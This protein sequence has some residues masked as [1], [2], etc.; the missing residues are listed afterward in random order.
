MNSFTF[1]QGAT[2]LFQ[3][4]AT[5]TG[6]LVINAKNV[7]SSS[8][9]NPFILTSYNGIATISS[10]CT[11]TSG[12]AITGDSVNGFTVDNLKIVNGSSTIYG[13]LLENQSTTWATQFMSVKNS[14]ITGFAPVSGSPNGGEIW[15]IGY[16]MNGNKGPLNNIQILN[17]SLHGA[18]ITSP[19]GVGVGGYGYGQ[20]ITNVLVQG[21]TVYNLGM[22]AAE[23]GAGILANGWKTGTIQRNQVHDIGANVTSCGGTSG[24]ETYNSNAVTVAYNEVF[25]VQPSPAYTAGCDWN[26]IDLDGGTTNSTVEYNYTHNNAGAGYLGY[27][28]N[29]SG[30]TWGP[31]TYRYNISENDDWEAAEGGAFAIVPNAPQNTVSIYSNTLFNNLAERGNATPACFYFG[32]A[33]GTWA[34][35]SLIEDNICDINNPS[36][37]ANLYNNPYGQTGMTLSNNLYFSSSNPTWIWGNTSYN[38]IALWQAAGLETAA[39]WGD[40]LFENPGNGG[41]CT[42]TPSSGTSQQPCP[43]AYQLHVGSPAFGNGV[44][45]TNNGALDYYQ[46]ALTT[47]PSIGAYSGSST[48]TTNTVVTFS[49]LQVSEY[50]AMPSTYQPVTGL[51]ITWNGLFR[52]GANSWDGFQDHTQET[53]ASAP[54]I[55]VGTLTNGSGMSNTGS[56]YFSRPVTIPSIYVTNWDWWEQDVILKGYTNISDATPAVTI[57]VP[58]S[59]IPYHATGTATGAWMQVTGMAGAAIQRLDVIGT[60]DSSAPLRLELP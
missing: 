37:G 17:N 55:D 12:A 49:D 50:S 22:P 29:P 45:V 59:N 32:Y 8:A 36:G 14:E 16:A 2:V 31:N 7:P 9:Q 39:I 58:Y 46:N 56:L 40:P 11:G 18:T 23:T 15:I 19:D 51:T 25:N 54:S 57:T 30:T 53:S 34:S 60:K 10:N 1:P 3:G 35:G 43:L 28:G 38:S 48:G 44:A 42:W 5:F 52:N 21:N 33:A 47:P 13:V 20:N 4:G 6:C 24:I 41:T 27:N 26:G